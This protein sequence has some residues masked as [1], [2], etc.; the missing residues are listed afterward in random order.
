M[1]QIQAKFMNKLALEETVQAK[2]V[3]LALKLHILFESNQFKETKVKV[4]DQETPKL[5]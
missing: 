5:M 2:E 3:Q 4:T 1:C